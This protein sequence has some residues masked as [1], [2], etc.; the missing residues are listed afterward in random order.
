MSKQRKPFTFKQFTIHQNGASLPVTT[1]ACLFGALADFENPKHI[2]DLGT[3][4]GLL[5]HF[6]AQKYPKATLTGID[7]HENS[8]KCAQ[9]NIEINSENLQLNKK[10]QLILGDFLSESI[11]YPV[12]KFDSIISN[13]PFFENQLASI[14]SEKSISRHFKNGDMNRFF[15]RVSILLNDHGTAWLLLPYSAI[16][17]SENFVENGLYITETV[18]LFPKVDQKQHLTMFKLK[19]IKPQSICHKFVSV[20]NQKGDY[21]FEFSQIMSPFYLTI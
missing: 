14:D 20:R 7:I 4:T 2:L 3:G 16:D 21:S 6:M 19:R 9:Y 15:K 18:D 5:L 10:T 11:P 8:L 12:T 13:P 17:Y 1:D